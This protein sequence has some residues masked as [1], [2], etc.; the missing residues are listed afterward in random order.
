MSIMPVCFLGHGNPMNAL[1]DNAY[2]QAWTRLG[3]NL[4]ERPQAVLCISAHWY[5]PLLAV[6]AMSH[7]R[8]IHDFGG[9][10]RELYAVKY[11][12]PG[13]P[14]L[15]QRVADLLAPKTVASDTAWGL[16]HGSWAVL[17]HVFP[18]ASIPIVQLSID[19]RLSF[20]EHYELAAHLQPLRDEG[21]FIVGSGNI[22]HNLE[23]AR[24]GSNDAVVYPWASEFDGFVRDALLARQHDRLIHLSEEAAM[25]SVPTPEHYLPLLYCAALARKTDVVT[26]PCEGID[27]ASISMRSV[28]FQSGTG[29]PTA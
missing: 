14:A 12:A 2:T 19:A 26:F 25:L 4:P 6:T 7:P 17:C 21:I 18:D 24:W 27:L 20:A 29:E 3:A 23:A 22:V 15:A 16:D 13:S 5:E 10:P 1:A 28:L 8:T 11:P 9:F